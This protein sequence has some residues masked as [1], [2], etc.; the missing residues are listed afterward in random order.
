MACRNAFGKMKGELMKL[1][2]FQYGK[3]Y[4]QESLALSG[5]NK[6]ISLP[7]SLL[8]FLI[9]EGDEKMLV[10][11]GCDTMPGFFLEEHISPV[12]LLEQH[13]VKREEITSVF[14]THAH[15]DHAECAHYYKNAAVF[16]H[17]DALPYAAGFLKENS[18]ISTFESE[19]SPIKGVKIIPV[20]G[21]AQ[22]S[23]I[24]AVNSPTGEFI[25]C[26]DECYVKESFEYQRLSGGVLDKEKMMDFLKKYKDHKGK[27]LFH[28]KDVVGYVGCKTIF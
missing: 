6:D 27:I 26:G 16:I 10:D 22:G 11:V 1:T 12:I 18:K 5:G 3:T 23:S 17:K 9:E 13:G 8:F 20:C 21:H 14:L 7:I 24:M 25:L 4:I 28:D 19:I 15:H 2:A